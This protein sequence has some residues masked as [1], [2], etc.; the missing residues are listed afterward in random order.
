MEIQRKRSESTTKVFVQI[1][2]HKEKFVKLWRLPGIAVST[3]GSTQ[4][5]FISRVQMPV[6]AQAMRQE[7]LFAFSPIQTRLK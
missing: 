1:P 5:I 3:G 2:F 4:L 6:I 7:K